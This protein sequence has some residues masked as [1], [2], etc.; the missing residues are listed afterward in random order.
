MRCYL[1]RGRG[2]SLVWMESR[3][4]AHDQAEER[5][6]KRTEGNQERTERGERA[7][8]EVRPRVRPVRRRSATG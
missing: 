3:Y 2:V 1:R 4:G 7:P 5:H 6:A 8:E